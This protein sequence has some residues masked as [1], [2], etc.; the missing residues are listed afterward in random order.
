MVALRSLT[1]WVTNVLTI[2]SFALLPVGDAA[3]ILYTF[4]L[5]FN[6]VF[7]C[8]LLGE[9]LILRTWL[10][11]LVNARGT[12]LVVRPA[13][14][15]GSTFAAAG[16]DDP[17]AYWQGVAVTVS[18]TVFSSIRPVLT[19]LVR[20]WHW[21]AVG[22]AACTMS[23]WLLTPL[24]LAAF[25]AADISAFAVAAAE[26]ACVFTGPTG[27]PVGARAD[28]ARRSTTAWRRSPVRGRR[29][30]C[31]LRRFSQ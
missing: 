24:A 8:L 18:A 1:M 28:G 25:Y 22:H 12:L 11:F 15:F 13:A 9:P 2:L 3:A 27:C 29:P 19:R 16:R 20:S 17:A 23:I 26:L 5:A 31:S 10:L 6:G 4:G 30:R 21:S 14:L 7:S